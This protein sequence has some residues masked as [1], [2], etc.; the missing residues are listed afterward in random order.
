MT[1]SL[2]CADNIEKWSLVLDDTTLHSAWPD[3]PEDTISVTVNA[4]EFGF[5][6]GAY[7]LGLWAQATDM[8]T[9]GLMAAILADSGARNLL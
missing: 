1:G 2:S 3:S 6:E 8:L 7:T 9:M 5:Q 4:E